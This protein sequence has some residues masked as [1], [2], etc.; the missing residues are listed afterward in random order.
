MRWEV[1]QWVALKLPN[2]LLAWPGS[3][4]L[5]HYGAVHVY[6]YTCVL[7][8]GGYHTLTKCLWQAGQGS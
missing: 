8:Q 6:V 2:K 7:Y 1:S 4:A 5:R 3:E